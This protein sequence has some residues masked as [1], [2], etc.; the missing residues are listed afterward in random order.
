MLLEHSALEVYYV[1]VQ[2]YHGY[3]DEVLVWYDKFLGNSKKYLKILKE[4]QNSQKFVM[5]GRFVQPTLSSSLLLL[6]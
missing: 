1:E 3:L 4:F 5:V 2:Q 6:S